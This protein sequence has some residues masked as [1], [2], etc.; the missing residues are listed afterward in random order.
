MWHH[1]LG[2]SQYLLARNWLQAKTCSYESQL[3]SDLQL[4]IPTFYEHD[5]ILQVRREFSTS[6][7]HTSSLS[8]RHSTWLMMEL[9][10]NKT[11]VN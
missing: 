3:S 11:K 6:K 10:L 5:D 7:A 8:I 2:P 1:F 9:L 4:A